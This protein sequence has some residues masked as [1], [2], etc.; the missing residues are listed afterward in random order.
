MAVMVDDTGAADPPPLAHIDFSA[1]EEARMNRLAWAM[2]VVGLLQSVL[3]GLGLL[4][5]LWFSVQALQN[6]ARAPTQVLPSIAL[7]LLGTGLPLYQGIV[8]REAG[9]FIGRAANTDDEDQE[10][11]AAAFRRLK[12]VFIIEAVLALPLV[13]WFF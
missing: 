8:L 13:L 5:A 3:S 9:E 10:H 1:A 6:V 11:I 7:A 2:G 12:V 4:M